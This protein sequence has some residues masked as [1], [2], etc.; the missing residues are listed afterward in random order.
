MVPSGV[1]ISLPVT[2]D[3]PPQSDQL[4][5]P[6]SPAAGPGKP[7]QITSAAQTAALKI[8]NVRGVFIMLSS[9]DVRFGPVHGA[10]A[11]FDSRDQ[12]LVWEVGAMSFVNWIIDVLEGLIPLIQIGMEG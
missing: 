8:A 12:R 10:L 5:A 9:N 6:H 4:A 2:Q 11:Y 1:A 7:A 3:L